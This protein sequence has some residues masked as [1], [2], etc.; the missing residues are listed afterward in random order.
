MGKF[1]G[2]TQ[3]G[4]QNCT[5]D[6]YFII[7]YH[8]CKYFI[9]VSTSEKPCNEKPCNGMKY[10]TMCGCVLLDSIRLGL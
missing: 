2:K 4:H 8:F 6:G 10:N 3:K 1:L 9:F 5:Y 7:M